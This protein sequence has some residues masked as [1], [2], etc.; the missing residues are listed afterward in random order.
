VWL[1][2]L[3][4]IFLLS[5]LGGC[6][7]PAN[8]D[9]SSLVD[10][11]NPDPQQTIDWTDCGGNIGDHGCDFT[12]ND[13]NDDP[14]T[15]YDHHGSIIVLDFSAMWCYYC[16]VA[17]ADVQAVQDMY[18]D[19]NFIWVTVLIDDAAGE[20]PDLSDIQEWTNTYGIETTPVLAGNREDGLLDPTGEDGYVVT[21]WPTFVILDRDLVI[22]FGLRGWNQ[23]IIL[24][25]IQKAINEG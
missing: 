5:V 10:S 3:T 25:E 6:T 2:N 19:D 1:K 11:S 9:D 4:V 23:Q 14:W 16:T 15:L 12:L 8:D 18:E 7:A 24:D 20:A 21:S 17:A 13:Q 22:R